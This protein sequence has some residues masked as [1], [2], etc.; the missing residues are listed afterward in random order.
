MVHLTDA[1]VAAF[2]GA[3]K[4]FMEEEVIDGRKVSI[5]PS[6]KFTSVTPSKPNEKPKTLTNDQR[7]QNGIFLRCVK[8]L[9]REVKVE[10]RDRVAEVSRKPFRRLIVSCD[11]QS[12]KRY[13]A[14]CEKGRA[15]KREHRQY[16]E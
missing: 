7:L 11:I 3:V 13:H 2:S 15:P 4:E 8:K 16:R 12:L 6:M 9:W 14:V 1:D 5:L 10:L